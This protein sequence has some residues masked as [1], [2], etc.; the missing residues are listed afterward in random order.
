MCLSVVVGCNE[1]NE[2]LTS[3]QEQIVRYLTSS[4]D[5]RLIAAEEVKDAIVLN[6]PFYERITMSIYRYI[7]TYYDAGRSARPKV[8]AGDEVELTFAAYTLSSGAPYSL[9]YTNDA[10]LIEQVAEQ[11][12][13]TEYWS[14]EPLRV[15]LGST[16]VIKGVAASLLDCHEGDVVEV[17]MAYDSAYDEDAVG[18]IPPKTGIAWF[19][20]INKVIKN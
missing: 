5:P 12:L 20:V 8:A 16:D 15:K 19:Y 7:A 14:T 4:H 11:G 17:Y 13:N 1:E 18:V 9:Y 6:P 10:S 2:D 3:Q